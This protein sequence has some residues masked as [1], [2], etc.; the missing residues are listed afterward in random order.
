MHRSCTIPACEF[1]ELLE[2][3]WCSDE[4]TTDVGFQS[5]SLLKESITIATFITLSETEYIENQNCNSCFNYLSP[6]YKCLL[7]H[8]KRSKF[9]SLDL[10]NGS[11]EEQLISLHVSILSNACILQY[12][13]IW[14]INTSTWRSLFSY[15]SCLQNHHYSIYSW[16]FE[17][18]LSFDG[19]Y[20]HVCHRHHWKKHKKK[21]H[22]IV[23]E[24]ASLVNCL[25]TQSS[26]N[27]LFSP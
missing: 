23:I 4:H 7:L 6:F 16:Q 9:V 11:M 21:T 27:F 22:K 13:D 12:L 2:Y 24:L 17:Q 26:S 25:H 15:Q 5:N 14:I 10:K 1:V 8:H 18:N 19:W 20:R 3:N